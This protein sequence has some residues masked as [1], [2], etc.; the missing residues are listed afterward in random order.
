M[1]L[2]LAQRFFNPE[3]KDVGELIDE[4]FISSSGKFMNQDN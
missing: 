4:E 3:G 2:H 1:K